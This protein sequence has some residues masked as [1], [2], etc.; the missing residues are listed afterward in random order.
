MVATLL[1]AFR[2]AA[3]TWPSGKRA[4]KRG[5]RRME[6][7]Q[8]CWHRLAPHCRRSTGRLSLRGG[9]RIQQFRQR[10]PNFG[11]RLLERVPHPLRQGDSTLRTQ[12]RAASLTALSGDEDL[13]HPFPAPPALDLLD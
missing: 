7:V 9:N 12:G 6:V 5:G 13:G 11:A 1:S 8:S 3:V 2:T 10:Q 4:F